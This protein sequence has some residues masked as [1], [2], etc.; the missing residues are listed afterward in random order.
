MPINFG[1][2]IAMPPRA[3]EADQPK[4]LAQC[5]DVFKQ[6]LHLP[7]DQQIVKIALGTVVG[8]F[9]RGI[10]PVWLVIIGS[11]SSGKTEILHAL[12]GIHPKIH[13]CN[14]LT[15]AGLFCRAKDGSLGGFLG[16][17]GS[18]GVGIMSDF[19]ELLDQTRDPYATLAILRTVYDGRTGR[20]I[21][22]E[23][24]DRI[25]WQGHFGL[26][27]GSASGI[28]DH[29]H[30]IAD[31]GERFVYYRPSPTKNDM[32]NAIRRGYENYCARTEQR[33][34]L[35]AAVKAAVLPAIE[36]ADKIRLPRTDAERDCIVALSRWVGQCRCVV[37]RDRRS[38]QKLVDSV[39]LPE[40]GAR[41]ANILM[42]LQ[43][44]MRIVGVSYADA[45]EAVRAVA[46][47]S[48]P[49][50]RRLVLE[51]I[52][53]ANGLT[54]DYYGGMRQIT[55]DLQHS[56]YNMNQRA[57][58][59]ALEDLELIGVLESRPG[60]N[61]SSHYRIRTEFWDLFQRV[62]QGGPEEQAD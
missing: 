42:G 16:R 19:S 58:S 2:V 60:G 52:I 43:Q 21:G 35:A 39:H 32:E 47:D 26:L 34:A 36:Y 38:F 57:T 3:P 7:N 51:T 24:G 8:N 12:L 61:K 6:W 17:I 4:R 54:R 62:V 44:G 27:A 25:E 18:R 23:G 1:K 46:W 50:E 30:A 55:R 11:P 13:E 10:D 41:I 9:I 37:K 56:G 15:P 14:R 29:R 20:D 5:L 31:M 45:W 59:F 22:L 49:L 53:S 40:T 48:I 33:A 28:D